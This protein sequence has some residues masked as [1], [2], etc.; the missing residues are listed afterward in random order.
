MLRVP[1]YFDSESAIA[2]S[3]NPIHQ[4][5]TKYIELR[6][7]FIKDHIL[8][9]NIKLIF[10]P[11]HE[12]IDDVITKALDASKLNSFLEMLGMMNLDMQFLLNW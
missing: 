8:N 2:I 3:E 12:E 10:V 5:K 4:S 1:I 6:Y 7:H 9:G 11:T